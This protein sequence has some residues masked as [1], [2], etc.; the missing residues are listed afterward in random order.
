MTTRWRPYGRQCID[1]DDIKAVVDVLR[2]DWLTTGPQVPAFEAE[3]AQAVGARYAVAVNSG[4]AALHTAMNAAGIA[5][6]D[7]VLVP[8]LT[9]AAS[10]NSVIYQGGTPVF[11]DV[12][13]NTLLI[14]IENARSK[15]NQRTKAI[16]AVD[17][18]GQ[19]CDYDKLNAL[20]DEYNLTLIADACHSLGGKYHDK[21]VGSLARLNTFSL[22]PVKPITSGEGGMI[23]TDDSRLAE[24][25]RR[26]RN[27]GI[28]TDHRQREKS[29]ACYYDMVSLGFN[30]RLTDL[31]AALGK[32]Q[33]AK[34]A[35][36]TRRRNEI[37]DCYDEQLAGIE[38]VTGL[39][40]QPDILHAY[41]LYV[42]RAES[43]ELRDYLFA[44]MRAEQIG[45][46]VHYRPVHMHP[47]Y[48]EEFC[49]KPG[50]CPVAEAAA[51]RILSLPIYPAMNEKDVRDIVSVLT[52]CIENYVESS[53][54]VS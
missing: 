37:A 2:S 20:A 21:P 40:K 29:G 11:V 54:S 14:D 47:Y 15:I 42:I 53:L 49:T 16:V 52:R 32:S 17:Y 51:A 36:W 50:L 12:D 46:T 8:A 4:T 27:H 30:Y 9:F 48:R 3:F 33:L 18:A 5:S 24:L 13:P 28:T 23:T 7:D 26:F 45:V 19:P 34:L 1:D 31:Q 22:H 38:Q 41:H 25:M 44:S 39:V 6:G 43:P 10:A 35:D